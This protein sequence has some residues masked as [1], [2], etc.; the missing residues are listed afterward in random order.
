M[1]S[2]R[3]EFGVLQDELRHCLSKNINLPPFESLFSTSLSKKLFDQIFT[4]L[5]MYDDQFR[6][7]NEIL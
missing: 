4:P 3:K 7:L 5:R 2:Q 6:V 1:E